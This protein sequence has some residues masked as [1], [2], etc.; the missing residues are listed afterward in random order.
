MRK[1]YFGIRRTPHRELE[2]VAICEDRHADN[3][4]RLSVTLARPGELVR[5]TFCHDETPAGLADALCAA[6]DWIRRGAP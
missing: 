4:L 6:A 3:E 1:P 2:L 5:D